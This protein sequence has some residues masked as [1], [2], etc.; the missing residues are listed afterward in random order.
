MIL[1]DLRKASCDGVVGVDPMGQR[2]RIFIDT[3]ALFG[4]FPQAT[5]FT[6]VLGHTATALCSLC[7][8]RKRKH[9]ITPETNY[10]VESHGARL[11]YARFDAR[12]QAIRNSRP[13]K[14]VLRALGMKYHVNSSDLCKDLPA[15][16]FSE[17]LKFDD[18]VGTTING[19][20]VLPRFLI[21]H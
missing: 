1:E 8:M 15:V 7:F 17:L 11:G 14:T 12:R 4:D 18:E 10:S 3:T 16:R 5:A 6:D 20:P 9:Q 2:V 19:H 21:M 13:D